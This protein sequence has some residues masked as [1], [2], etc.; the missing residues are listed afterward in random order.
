MENLLYETID[1]KIEETPR[2]TWKSF[3]GYNG[4]LFREF[5]SHRRV[6]GMPLLHY[7]YGRDPRTGRRKVA[8]GF[9]AVGRIAVGVFALGQL[10]IG[11]IPVG[12]AAFG[13]LLGFGQL[14]TGVVAIGQVAIGLLFGLGQIA[15]GWV[16]IG[17]I[18]VGFFSMGQITWAT[19]GRD[20][21]YADPLA[22]AFF[23]KWFGF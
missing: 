20:M 8:R 21:R 6:M 23:R 16:S 13:L 17:Q 1:Y 9:V 11:I 12:Q 15:T 18:A 22:K 19:H 14:A 3:M 5:T 7:T 4:Q 2:G 10:A